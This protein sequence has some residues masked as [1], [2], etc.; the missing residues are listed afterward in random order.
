MRQTA[1]LIL[2]GAILSLAACTGTLGDTSGN[3]VGGP[4]GSGDTNSVMGADGKPV[5]QAASARMRRLTATEINNSIRDIFGDNSRPADALPKDP[6]IETF[7][8]SY[9]KLNISPLFADQMQGVAEQVAATAVT[10]LPSLLPCALA[11]VGETACAQQF[12]DTI[13]LKVFRRPL[14]EGERSAA[15]TLYG[16]ARKLA[17]ATTSVRTVI[18]YMLQSPQFL[19]R[20][21]LGNGVPSSAGIAGLAPYEVAASLSYFLWNSTPD[22]GLLTAA[23]TGTLK[24]STDVET[25]ARRMLADAKA[26]P[27]ID[28]FFKQWLGIADVGN[29]QKSASMF[30]DFN[31]KVAQS[32]G[33]ETSAFIANVMWNG[34]GM[35]STL[36]TS[37]DTFANADI[38][39]LYGMT[40]GG[41]SSDFRP[42]KADGTRRAGFLTHSS[43]IAT[44]TPAGDTSPILSGKFVR[45]TLFCQVLP[46]PPANI[47]QVAPPSGTISTR[48]RFAGHDSAPGCKTCHSLMDPIGWG[49]EKFD[50]IGRS[51]DAENGF[52][53]TGK[54]NLSNTDVDGDFVGPV[55]LANKLTQSGMVKSCFAKQVFRYA[56]GR[57]DA[58]YDK[59]GLDL[60][61]E[62]FRSARGAVKELM[63]AVV[64][65]DAFLFR[66]VQSLGK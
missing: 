39:K 25:Q 64:T 34:D 23:A 4:G 65:T 5:V 19:F 11:G 21:E 48:Q 51:R 26:K 45:E 37:N 17:D 56:M 18:E 22:D 30:P 57:N 62:R 63:V 59:S 27:A 1:G 36:L 40:G 10:K 66:N 13:G 8:N 31:A 3:G 28:N 52:A 9:D 2:S 14:M 33:A 41:Y 53:L 15:L 54:G 29:V 7:D 55:E 42:F 6:L 61:A 43:V 46:A 44:H 16:D 58:E 35:L 50:G 24:S 49:F 60:A 12:I 32:M 38:A 20:T 47:P